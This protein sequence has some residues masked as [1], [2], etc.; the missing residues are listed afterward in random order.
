MAMKKS[1]IQS[2]RRSNLL[3]G[4]RLQRRFFS[5]HMKAAAKI[6]ERLEDAV[7]SNDMTCWVDIIKLT[8]I[9]QPCSSECMHA[10]ECKRR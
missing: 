6:E 5:A 1:L 3:V 7:S 10:V 2:E 9:Q 8:R 4:K